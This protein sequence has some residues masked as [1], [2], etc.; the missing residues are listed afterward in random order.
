MGSN[1]SDAKATGEAARRV[2]GDAAAPRAQALLPLEDSAAAEEADFVRLAEAAIAARARG[3][4]AARARRAG[5]NG[6]PRRCLRARTT[7]RL[8]RSPPTIAPPR[9]RPL[10][11]PAS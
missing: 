6:G 11:S 5:G 9:R 7:G 1:L 8:T 2:C 4:G 3:D 10:Q